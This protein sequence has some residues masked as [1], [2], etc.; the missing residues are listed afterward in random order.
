MQRLGLG[1]LVKSQHRARQY[2]QQAVAT[3]G[4]PKV[5]DARL[6][7]QLVCQCGISSE[8]VG[9]VERS[10]GLL[11]SLL[12]LRN[13]RI[14]PAAVRAV[15]TGLFGAPEISGIAWHERS[16]FDRSDEGNGSPTPA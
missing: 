2:G 6:I 16:S 15:H 12:G 7:R 13:M 11:G 4:R 3:D 1:W 10:R 5:E 9:W 14:R 8:W